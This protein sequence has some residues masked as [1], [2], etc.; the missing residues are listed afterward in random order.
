[1]DG[2]EVGYLK[3][4][5]ATR[6]HIREAADKEPDPDIGALSVDIVTRQLFSHADLFAVAGGALLLAPTMC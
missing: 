5:D 6:E 3:A 4:F 2:A 1:M